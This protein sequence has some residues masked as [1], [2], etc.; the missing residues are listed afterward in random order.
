MAKEGD[1][2]ESLLNKEIDNS[3][4]ESM[5]AESEYYDEGGEGSFF[6]PFR[7]QTYK[8][9]IITVLPGFLIYPV[10]FLF[11]SWY[12]GLEDQVFRGEFGSLPEGGV[13]EGWITIRRKVGVLSS[14]ASGIYFIGISLRAWGGIG[15]GMIVSTISAYISILFIG[16]GPL[17]TRPELWWRDDSEK[18]ISILLITFSFLVAYFILWLSVE[19]WIRLDE[20]NLQKAIEWEEEHLPVNYFSRKRIAGSSTETK[21]AD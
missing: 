11:V 10:V 4:I 21:K 18:T 13:I 16:V 8:E 2:S 5:K 17:S 14:F 15:I 12:F 20:R 6:L 3:T 9:L 1:D 19:F 7:G